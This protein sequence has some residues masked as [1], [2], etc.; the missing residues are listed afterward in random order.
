MFDYPVVFVDIETTGGSVKNS[1]VIEVAAIR[2][3]NGQVVREFSSLIN[4]EAHIPASITAFT[5]ITSRDVLSAPVFAGIASELAD[6]MN[7]A[8]FIAHNVR[9][10]YSFLRHEFAQLGVEFSPKL[11]C[12]VRLSRAL[13]AQHKGHSLAT[14]IERHAIPVLARHRALDDARAMMH[15]TQLAFNEHGY[16]TFTAAV[17]RQLKTQLLPLNLTMFEPGL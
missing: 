7:G 15:F 1:R 17:M 6:V 13:Y 4:P 9:F 12:T 11:L 2:F 16:D 3:E 10:D 14:L 8:I 5:G